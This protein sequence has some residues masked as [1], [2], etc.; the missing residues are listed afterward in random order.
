VLIVSEGLHETADKD[1][2]VL[3]DALTAGITALWA[4][5]QQ[6]TIL[7]VDYPKLEF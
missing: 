3:L 6:A 5:P 4:T 7:T 2:C 1:V